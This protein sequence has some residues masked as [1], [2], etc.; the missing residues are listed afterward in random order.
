MSGGRKH[1]IEVQDSTGKVRGYVERHL[2]SALWRAT[3]KPPPVW[4]GG[5]EHRPTLQESGSE[6]VLVVRL[7]EGAPLPKELV[8]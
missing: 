8:R 6:A 3:G 2:R 4:L 1:R 7:P 5:A